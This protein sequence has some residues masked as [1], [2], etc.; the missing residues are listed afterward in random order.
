MD[1]YIGLDAHVS[2]CTFGVV[3]PSGKRLGHQ[4]V[5]TNAQAL[6]AA[7]RAIPG[8][9][10]LCLEEGTLSGWLYEVLSPHVAELVVAG[11]S[12]SQGAKNDKLDAFA[13]AEQLRIGAIQKK[14][15]KGQG[16]FARLR[17][18]AKGYAKL[19]GDSV[20]V[21]NR[22]KSLLRSRGLAAS[23]QGV[24]ARRSREEWLSRLPDSARPQA[25]LLYRQHD[26]L[27]E[28]RGGLIEVEPG[29][30]LGLGWVEGGRLVEVV[31]GDRVHRSDGIGAELECA[32]G[33]SA[34]GG[35][36]GRRVRLPASAAGRSP[37]G[38]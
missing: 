34:G 6:V 9:R 37:G 11:V 22:I 36:S 15:Y 21:Q 32:L 19:V 29:E 27:V 5:E 16:R 20:R 12:E 31:S 10:H 8:T 14:V 23:G 38:S 2:S 1:R 17:H 33:R 13:R 35:E 28:L 30:G 25:E 7:V 24:Y 3:G 26:A 18:P 4:V